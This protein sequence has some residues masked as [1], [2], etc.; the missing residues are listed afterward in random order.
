LNNIACTIISVSN[1]KIS[2]LT[3][4]QAVGSYDFTVTYNSLTGTSLPA[5]QFVYNTNAVTVTSF[6]PSDAS[7]VL[8]GTIT[9]TGTDFGLD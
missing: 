6:T 1:T 5:D 8:K 4:A 3:P 7:P 9:I 2:I